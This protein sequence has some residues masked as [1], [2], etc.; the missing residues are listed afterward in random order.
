MGTDTLTSRAIVAARSEAHALWTTVSALRGALPAGDWSE[1]AADLQ[2]ALDAVRD[3]QRHLAAAYME[4]KGDE[5]AARRR[6][7][8]DAE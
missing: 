2:H 3:V 4:V 5:L 8:L 6:T 7:G 1:R